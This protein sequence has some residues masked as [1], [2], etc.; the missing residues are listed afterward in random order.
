M[1]AMSTASPKKAKKTA[2]NSRR[3]A[4]VEMGQLRDI[5]EVI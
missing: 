4:S 1:T 5:A 3:S 2:R